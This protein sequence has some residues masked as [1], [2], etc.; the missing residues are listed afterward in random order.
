MRTKRLS[1]IFILLTIFLLTITSTVAFAND[2]DEKTITIT[3]H[4]HREVQ[5][6]LYVT[7]TAIVSYTFN[8]EAHSIDAHKIQEG[9][10]TIEYVTCQNEDNPDVVDYLINMVDKHYSLTIYDC[11]Y[12][13]TKFTISNHMSEDVVLEMYGYEDYEFEA[14]QGKTKHELFS[15]VYTYYYEACEGKSFSGEVNV[16][17]N[18]QTNLILHSCEWHT[19]PAQIFGGPNPVGFKIVNHASFPVIMTLIGPDS[20]LVTA[21]YGVNRME[22]VSG[23]YKYSY[24]QDL[25]LKTGN[26]VVTRNGLGVLVITPSYTIGL[27]EDEILE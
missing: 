12:Q 25:Q 10:Y 26:F 8:V 22:L 9:V 6:T 27:V 5:V 2:A 15:G 17:K 14:E 16:L 19:S 4:S 23:T 18:G 11:A 24:Y 21:E 1:L 3:N 20:Y 7:E 13:P